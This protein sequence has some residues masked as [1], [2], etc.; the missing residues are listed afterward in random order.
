MAQRSRIP[1]VVGIVGP[2]LIGGTLIKQ[3]AAQSR[4]LQNDLFINM[5]VIAIISTRTMYLYNQKGCDLDT[6]QTDMAVGGEQ[7]DLQ[8][9]TEFFKGFSKCHKVIIDC[10]ADAHVPSLYTVWLSSGIHVVTPNK[11]LCSGPLSDWTKVKNA[12]KEHGT[13]FKYEGTVGAGLPIISTLSD[14]MQ[15]GDKILHI[16]GILSGTLS[17]IFNSLGAGKT[18]SEV[19]ADAKA[20]GFTEPDPREDLAGTDVARKMVILGR[21]CGLAIEMQQVTVESLVPPQL[22]DAKSAEDFMHQLPQ[23]LPTQSSDVVLVFVTL[24]KLALSSTGQIL[25]Q[26]S[27]PTKFMQLLETA[28]TH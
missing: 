6:W 22:A 12:V 10:T 7:P 18:F 8:A 27:Q 25:Y 4:S 21:E 23:V 15:T 1:I 17:F 19:V 11:K 9:F 28:L 2:G 13:H 5:H 3:L 16:E 24:Y 26:P 14:L 20:K